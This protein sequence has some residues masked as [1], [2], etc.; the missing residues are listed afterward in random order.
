MCKLQMTVQGKIR[1]ITSSTSSVHAKAR[2]IENSSIVVP[3]TSEDQFFEIG[4]AW[5]KEAKKKVIVHRS[6]IAPMIFVTTRNLCV[7]NM[8]R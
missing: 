8:L 2:Y 6:T 4:E 7:A 5:N 1:I 3:D